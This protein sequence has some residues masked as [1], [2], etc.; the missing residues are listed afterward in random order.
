MVLFLPIHTISNLKLLL[1]P[2]FTQPQLLQPLLLLSLPLLTRRIL[3]AH[4]EL[5]P[6]VATIMFLIKITVAGIVPRPNRALTLILIRALL[7][8]WL[9]WFESWLFLQGI[10]VDVDDD[11][12][13]DVV[14]V[15]V[16]NGGTA[17]LLLFLDQFLVWQQWWLLLIACEGVV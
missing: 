15:A 3:Q 5:T 4:R 6:L 12:V 2:F 10:V 17:Q 8:L 13:V 9:L 1:L 7:S 16:N 11:V 14:G